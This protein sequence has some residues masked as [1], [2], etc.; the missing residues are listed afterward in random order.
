LKTS[1][2]QRHLLRLRLITQAQHRHEQ[3]CFRSKFNLFPI[4]RSRITGKNVPGV[5]YEILSCVGAVTAMYLCVII[6]QT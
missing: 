6:T 2:T 4:I 5:L 1:V 3:R